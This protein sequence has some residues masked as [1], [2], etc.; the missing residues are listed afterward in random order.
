MKNG[1]TIREPT[2]MRLLV[3]IAFIAREQRFL[4][5]RWRSSLAPILTVKRK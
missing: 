5:G 4:S 2:M 1:N 3:P